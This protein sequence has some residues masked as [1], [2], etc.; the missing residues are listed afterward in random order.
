MR[1]LIV[2]NWGFYPREIAGRPPSQIQLP[3][4]EKESIRSAIHDIDLGHIEDNIFESLS[5]RDHR[6]LMVILLV[7]VSNLSILY[8]HVSS[9][10]SILGYVLKMTLDSET[11]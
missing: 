9:F 7:S 4:E 10:D 5:L 8:A 6:P 3:P 1:S 2:A 11:L